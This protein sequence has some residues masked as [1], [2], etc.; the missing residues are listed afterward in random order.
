[1]MAG[2]LG[3]GGVRVNVVD[4]GSMRTTMRAAAYPDEDPET[5]PE[6]YDVTEVFVYLASDR[7]VDVNGQ[8]FR[9]KEFEVTVR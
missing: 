3:E 2:E 6:P 4:P 7:S 1:M 8:R 5:L 9:A